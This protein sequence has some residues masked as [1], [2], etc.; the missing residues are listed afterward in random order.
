MSYRIYPMVYI[1]RV[2]V[3]IENY[4]NK[5]YCGFLRIYGKFEEIKK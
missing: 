4:I 5:M 1:Y 2:Y 3:N